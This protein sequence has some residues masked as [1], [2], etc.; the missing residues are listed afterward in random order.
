MS[1]R[2]TADPAG[3]SGRAVRRRQ[4]LMLLGLGAASALAGCGKKGPLRL[5]E[6]PPPESGS[7]DEET[8]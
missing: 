8:K 1:H 3:A 5:P 2:S 4:L 6:P 7:S